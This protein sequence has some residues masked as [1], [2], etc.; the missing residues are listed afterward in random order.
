MK[1]TRHKF[2]KADGILTADWHLQEGESP[3][4]R[5]DNFE[6]AQWEKVRFISNL[7][8]KHNC[9]VI[10]SGDLVDYWKSSP[11]LL[12]KIIEY[13]P[14]WFWSIY[15]NHDLPQHNMDLVHKCSQ[16]MLAKGGH[17]DILPNMGDWLTT[18]DDYKDFAA[19][20]LCGRPF[21]VWHIMTYQGK[22]PW[23][24]CTSPKGSALLRKYPQYDLIVTG[25]NHKP[26]VEEYQG[27]LLVNP[28]SIFRTTAAQENHRPRVYLWYADTNTVEPVYIPINTG[29]ISREHIDK[30]QERD[31]R[32]DAFISTLNTDFKMELSFKGYLKEFEHLN[33]I[34]PPILDIIYKSMKS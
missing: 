15:G 20:E 23:P 8:K 27:R 2:K 18:P 1:R 13:L 12:A 28:G 5:I 33:N 25:D 22:S 30:K 24:G 26:F 7:Q 10:H 17:L 34:K 3:V 31:N 9:P 29:A 16:Y 21:F 19:P 6:D 4:C 14:K 32:I 11:E